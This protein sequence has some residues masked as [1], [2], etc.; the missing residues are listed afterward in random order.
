MCHQPELV[1]VCQGTEDANRGVMIF[2]SRCMLI[3]ATL[4]AYL[5]TVVCAHVC[6][7]AELCLA[8]SC[9]VRDAAGANWQAAT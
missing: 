2:A 6:T 4:F 9:L 5:C 8:C 7:L 1:H 3:I